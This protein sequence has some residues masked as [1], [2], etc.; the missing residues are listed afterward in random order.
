VTA[1]ES[2][3]TDPAPRQRA[4]AL[5]TAVAFALGWHLWVGDAH[6]NAAEEGYLWY[7]TWRTGLGELPLRDFQS[8]DPGRYWA[9]AALGKLFGAGLLGLRRSEALFQGLGILFGLLAARRSTKKS[10]PLVP[11][12]ILLGVWLFPRHKVFEGVL[13]LGATWAGTRLLERPTRA[14]HVV[15]GACA[16]LAAV[17]GRNHGL[18]AAAGFLVLFA[19]SAWKRRDADWPRK[20]AAL[21]GGVVLGYAPMLLAFFVAPGFFAGF[22]DS[23]LLLLRLGTNIESPWLWPW[24]LELA[25]LGA[26]DACARMALALVYLLPLV[27]LPLGIWR[28][29]RARAEELAPRALFLAA[30]VLGALYLHHASVRSDSSHLAQSIQP[31]LLAAAA[32]VALLAARRRGLALT[33]AL[34]LGSAV[35]LAG[36][37]HN[38][39]TS[40]VG[41]ARLVEARLGAETLRLLPRHAEAYARLQRA[42]G[43]RLAPDERLF[44]APSRP[45]YY[46]LFQKKSPS[47]WIYFFVPEAERAEQERIVAELAGVEWVLIV[48]QAIAEREDLR[49]RNS[50]PLVWAHVQTSY[51]RVPTPEL[52]PDHLLFRLRQ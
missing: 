3:A 18:Y 4:L 7:G 13:A 41:R 17:F 32:G 44:V 22:V 38:P 50:Y 9:C 25:G 36:F 14:A 40:H 15:A 12:G 26:L 10:W 23:L 20:G 27:V 43:Q 31:S 8:Y 1:P 42:V 52:E 11:L 2:L 29:L 37:E 21:A 6:L 46:A 39:A 5:L 49:F 28:L 47:W 48:D 45:A 16:G 35:A 34:V 24:T 30:S 51:R 33:L 19:A